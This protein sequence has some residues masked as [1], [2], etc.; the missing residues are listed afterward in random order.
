MQHLERDADVGKCAEQMAGLPIYKLT[1]SIKNAPEYAA[2]RRE[3]LTSEL[4]GGE[5]I[6][7]AE[8]AAPHQS[9]E[10]GP[11]A[12]SLVFLSVDICNSTALRRAN[13]SAFD[14]AYKLLMRELATVVGHFRGTILKTT[15]DG[16]IAYI[17]HPAF[18]QQCDNAVDM[19]LSLL[20]VLRDSVNPSLAHAQLPQISIRV[21]A[22]YGIAEMRHIDVP[23]TGF[24][25]SEIASDALNKAVKIQETANQNEFR[26]GWQLYELIHVQWLERST[27]L[28][29]GFLFKR[30][31]LNLTSGSD[32][33]KDLTSD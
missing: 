1:P 22:D 33:A 16:F 25:A 10:I 7:P 29:A 21:A 27:E 26:I 30:R 12:K 15:G 18:T 9:L 14:S 3:A 23:T 13:R 5:Y 31:S 28:V 20:R 19:G 32:T 24:S 11:S 4:S 6:A 17:D 2:S 8:R